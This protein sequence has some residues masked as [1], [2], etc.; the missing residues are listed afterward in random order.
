MTETTRR[1]FLGL[2]SGALVAAI[3][4]P[5]AQALIA[6]PAGAIKL[7]ARH[8]MAIELETDRHVNHVDVMVRDP[9][10]GW[11]QYGVS[12]YSASR[13]PAKHE[14]EPALLVLENHIEHY[15]PGTYELDVRSFPVEALDS[16]EIHQWW[17]AHKIGAMA[18]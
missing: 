2:L 9:K 4:A 17:G 14:I 6:A 5:S 7:K 8:L 13:I 1:G 16:Q 10:S 11:Q 12:F 3:A 18:A 15:H